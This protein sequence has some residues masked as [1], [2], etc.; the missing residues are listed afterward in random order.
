MGSLNFTRRSERVNTEMGL[1]LDCPTLARGIIDLI[2]VIP[3]YDLRI[4]TGPVGLEWVDK[5]SSP[6][7]AVTGEPGANV[8]SEFL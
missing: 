5:Q 1:I 4:A 7:R 8:M 3:A 2:Q 6:E